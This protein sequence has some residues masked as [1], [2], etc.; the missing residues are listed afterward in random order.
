MILRWRR[1]IG[2]ERGGSE[3]LRDCMCVCVCV[4]GG[5]GGFW[6]GG[7]CACVDAGEW[8]G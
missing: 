2:R 8:E 4:W 5:G 7:V 3:G 1:E 6:G